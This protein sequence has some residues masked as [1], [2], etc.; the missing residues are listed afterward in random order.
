MSDFDF[1]AFA[2]YC[3]AVDMTPEQAIADMITADLFT[4]RF[5][6]YTEA[7]KSYK[8]N[9]ASTAFAALPKK[10]QSLVGTTHEQANAQINSMAARGKYGTFDAEFYLKT[11]YGSND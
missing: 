5:P 9:V 3:D 2:K 10:M 4:R 7:R 11:I 8:Q 1:A 6:S